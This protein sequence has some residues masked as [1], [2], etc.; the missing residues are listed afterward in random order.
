M[1]RQ[2]MTPTPG[3]PVIRCVFLGYMWKIAAAVKNTFG[4]EL[5][6]VGIEPQRTRSHEIQ[7]FCSASNQQCFDAR[8]IRKNAAFEMLLETGVDIIVVGAFGQILSPEILSRPRFGTINFHPSRLPQYRGGS[9]LEE[10]ILRGETL[11]GVTAHWMSEEVDRGSLIATQDMPINPGDDYPVLYER[12]H[13]VAGSLMMQLLQSHPGSWPRIDPQTETPVY[14][15]RLPEDGHIDWSCSAENIRRLVCALGWRGWVQ[16]CLS[17]GTVITIE[18]AQSDIG[19]PGNWM[20]GKVIEAGNY[21]LIGTG[22]GILRLKTF[23]AGKPLNKGDE[24][25]S[26]KNL[27]SSSV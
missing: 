10:Q 18:Q 14:K 21:P 23:R 25:V 19:S 26:A 16:S 7:S 8:K 20:P 22:E 6:S 5:L 27:K 1:I 9:P 2:S 3:H 17:D 4:Y 11:S 13:D 24:L 15:P 12:A